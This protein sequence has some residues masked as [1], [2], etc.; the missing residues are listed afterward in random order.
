MKSLKYEGV[1]ITFRA[2]RILHLHY[3]DVFLKIDDTKRIFKFVRTNCPWDKSP[4]YLTGGSF[5]S[6]DP[7]SRTFNGSTEV[8]KH[9][10]AIAMLST[11]LAQKMLANF[12]MRIIKPPVPTK[13]F[14]DEKEALD[15]LR[16][17]ETVEKKTEI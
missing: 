12:F 11:S 5:T 9:C 8:T 1:I 17:F 4:V 7:A 10:S 6:Q 2:D 15:W 16:Q 13:S 14:S 3:D